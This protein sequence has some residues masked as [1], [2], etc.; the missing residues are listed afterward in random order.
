MKATAR[1]S[2]IIPAFNAAAFIAETLA[3][4]QAQ[5]LTD[6][7][8]VVVDDG[9]TDGT[10]E[11]VAAVAARDGRVRLLRQANSGPGAARNH[12]LR[13]TT[14]P[15]VLF[16]DSDDLPLPHALASFVSVLEARP[17]TVGVYGQYETFGAGIRPEAPPHSDRDDFLTRMLEF[18]PMGLHISNF[19]VR[20]SAVEA[21]GGWHGA[22]PV[23]EDWYLW[24]R[25]ARDAPSG[26]V[27]LPEL[28]MRIRRH[29]GQLS[30]H[31]ARM[32]ADMRLAQGTARRLGAYRSWLYYRWCRSLFAL[33]LAASYIKDQ[34]RWGAGLRCAL[35]A[36]WWHPV[37]V[38]LRVW[39]LAVR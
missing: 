12:G 10:A 3:A 35:E 30:R 14:A 5:T 32:E 15:F 26:V 1:V 13:E 29:G 2:V 8:A 17:E 28:T 16:L 27:A 25:L 24:V 11:V 34:G 18:V 21:I 20:R 19:M 9:S 31:V 39:W 23:C 7:E 38:A 33:I 37:P 36:L 4:L 6:W 22:F